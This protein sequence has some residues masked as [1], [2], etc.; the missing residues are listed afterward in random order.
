MGYE[1]GGFLGFL[2]L[3]LNIWAIVKVAKSHASSLMKFVWIAVILIL[4][5]IG[6]IVWY[7]LGPKG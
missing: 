3:L 5:V 2:V 6:V 7:L 4:P 1:V